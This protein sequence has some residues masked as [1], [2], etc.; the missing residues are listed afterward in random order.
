MT[1]DTRLHSN[2]NCVGR[3]VGFSTYLFFFLIF[4]LS[5]STNSYAEIYKWVDENGVVHFSDDESSIPKILKDRVKKI[6]PFKKEGNDLIKV[7]IDD[8]SVISLNKDDEGFED[9]LFGSDL[10]KFLSDNQGAALKDK[11][12]DKKSY[13]I[14]NGLRRIGKV[15]VS[16]QY[17]FNSAK[18]V[19]VNISYDDQDEKDLIK[20]LALV[21]GDPDFKRFPFV[22]WLNDVIERKVRKDEDTFNI[23]KKKI[24]NF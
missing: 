8:L 1:F 11:N 7:N 13:I 19:K 24:K 14:G 17:I 2:A 16:V 18:L 4:A 3:V 22:Y 20:E 15:K 23:F 9:I 12:G 6:K 21:L 10:D 5:I